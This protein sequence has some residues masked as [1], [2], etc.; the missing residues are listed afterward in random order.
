MLLPRR[1]PA[2]CSAAPPLCGLLRPPP[3]L[4]STRVTA[5]VGPWCCV[6]QVRQRHDRRTA[7]RSTHVTKHDG[8]YAGSADDRL[9]NFIA[10][11]GMSKSTARRLANARVVATARDKKK[12]VDGRET[13]TS[14]HPVSS[15]YLSP[16]RLAANTA[17]DATTTDPA[18]LPPPPVEKRE[19]KV[20][21]TEHGIRIDSFLERRLGLRKNVARLKVLNGEVS[22]VGSAHARFVDL[23]PA[24]TLAAGDV[25][26]VIVLAS[27]SRRQQSRRGEKDGRDGTAGITHIGE[28]QQTRAEK[29]DAAAELD[30]EVAKMK[31]RVLFK[32]KDL[33]VLDKPRG[34]A[35]QGGSKIGMHLD[36]ILEGMKFDDDDGH[37]ETP[38]LV[39]RLDRD[40][41]GALLLARS[42]KAAARIGAMLKNADREAVVK[43]YI[44]VLV[45]SPVIPTANDAGADANANAGASSASQPSP[46]LPT[47]T[48]HEIT[49]GMLQVGRTGVEKMSIVEWY[50]QDETHPDPNVK[51][52]L[53]RWRILDSQKHASLVELRPATGRKHQ[54]RVHCS[55]VLKASIFGDYKY[56]GV[57]P[58][59]TR[60]P[61]HLHMR[62]L[63]LKDWYGPGAHLH[64]TAPI[65][66]H[67]RTTMKHLDLR[68]RQDKG[69]QR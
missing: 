17:E 57:S 44:A 45:Q 21:F 15:T 19:F 24:G 27:R 13:T 1:L 3:A 43:S 60:V 61:L 12:K 64:V 58:D 47:D 59:P 33:I 53:T 10:P 34:L 28:Q 23:K 48:F 30:A 67:M 54:L 26:V 20:D 32:D 16:R 62:E 25:V 31:K 29:R 65:P 49:T 6:Q 69:G 22:V 7:P 2:S 46:P 41:T 39:H 38:R 36:K 50:D 11:P 8:Q 42:A 14:K 40:T 63:T 55:M 35:V 18:L 68:M 56:G 51:K 9:A 66:S 5:A 4:A 37:A 52:A